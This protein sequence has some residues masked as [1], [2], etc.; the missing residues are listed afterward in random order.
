M[1]CKREVAC[2]RAYNLYYEK[3]HF[4]TLSDTSGNSGR[5]NQGAY[6]GIT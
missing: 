5:G 6:L 4:V 3:V 2:W 1:N